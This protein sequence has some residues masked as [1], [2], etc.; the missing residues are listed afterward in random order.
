MSGPA[1]R[2]RDQEGLPVSHPASSSSAGGVSPPCDGIDL[3]NL[4][5]VLKEAAFSCSEPQSMKLPWEEDGLN[6][7]F[8]N[9]ALDKILESLPDRV[10]F[11]VPMAPDAPVEIQAQAAKKARVFSGEQ[12]CFM[13]CVNF[14][15]QATDAELEEGAWQTSL[16]MWRVILTL[17]P[18]VYCP[19]QFE[20]A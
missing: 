10:E 1:Q 3:G 6:L 12:P 11:P 17:D 7:I 8:E 4:N 15:N 13:N 5:S 18:T 9:S 16:E 20:C 14:K 19:V 2:K